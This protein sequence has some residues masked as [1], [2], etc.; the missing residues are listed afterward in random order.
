MTTR[1]CKNCGKRLTGDRRRQTCSPI[2]RKHHANRRML[3]GAQVIDLAM[4]WR[5]HRRHRSFAAMI[6]LVDQFLLEDQLAGKH[7]M[8]YPRPVKPRP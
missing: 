8:D 3:R 1:L 7:R 4:H 2:C 5:S 6:A